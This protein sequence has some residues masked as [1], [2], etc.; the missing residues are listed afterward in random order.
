[1]ACARWRCSIA[2]ARSA[3]P[4]GCA[5]LVADGRI[6]AALARDLIDALHFL[7][8]LKLANNLRQIADGRTPDNAI[9]LTE[10]GTLERQALK[11]SLAIVRGSSSGW[12]GTTGWTRCETARRV[13][14]RP[15]SC[16]GPHEGDAAIRGSP[17]AAQCCSRSGR[18]LVLFNFPMLIVWDRDATVFGLPLL[19]VAL[20]AIWAALIAALAWAIDAAQSVRRGGA[21]P[22]TAE[23]TRASDRAMI[24]APLVLGVSFGYLLLLFAIAAFG[25]RRAAARPLGDRQR[26]DLRAVAGGLLHRLDLFRQRRARGGV[27]G[28]VPADLPRADAGDAAGLDRACAR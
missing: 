28:L 17:R 9:R 21:P 1:M 22:A 5:A 25:D 18:G 27:R 7:M 24:S 4:T 11:D 23:P 14:G 8:G 16:Q 6:D 3:P 26:L 13:P 19:P 12:A 20:F 2:C 15:G 10:L